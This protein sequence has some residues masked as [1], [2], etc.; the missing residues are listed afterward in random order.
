[1]GGRGGFDLQGTLLLSIWKE[2]GTW[3]MG[4]GSMAPAH[5]RWAPAKLQVVA[6]GEF[7]GVNQLA[8]P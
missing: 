3:R 6:T 2:F 1:M 7:D 5:G 4:R 8:G